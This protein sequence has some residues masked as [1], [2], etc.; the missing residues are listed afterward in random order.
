MR[1]NI[2]TS[3]LS[4]NS[5]AS[6]QFWQW[7]NTGPSGAHRWFY[8]RQD[9]EQICFAPS[10]NMSCCDMSSRSVLVWVMWR[11]GNSKHNQ[12]V[13]DGIGTSDTVDY[14]ITAYHKSTA[15]TP[16]RGFWNQNSPLGSTRFRI[17]LHHSWPGNAISSSKAPSNPMTYA[18]LPSTSFKAF[19]FYCA[20]MEAQHAT[21]APPTVGPSPPKLSSS[22][23]AEAQPQAGLPTCSAPK[24]SANSPFSCCL[25]PFSLSYYQLPW[26][27]PSCLS[28]QR[29]MDSYRHQQPR[30]YS[31]NQ[32]WTCHHHSLRRRGPQPRVQHHQC[33]PPRS[34]YMFGCGGCGTRWENTGQFSCKRNWYQWYSWLFC[35][36]IQG[37]YGYGSQDACR[38]CLCSHKTVS[39]GEKLLQQEDEMSGRI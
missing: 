21:P 2:K 22:G 26:H 31:P 38:L 24:A 15:S 30:P 1:R 37:G 23:N 36:C 4:R 28:K 14:F 8:V 35:C 7:P 10:K 3:F 29:T 5:P 6:H 18:A 17:T 32:G 19:P 27:Q 20:Q 16:Q 34:G 39:F 33:Q 9:A 13:M 12:S 11:G 25:R